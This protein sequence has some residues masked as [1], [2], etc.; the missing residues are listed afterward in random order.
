MMMMKASDGPKE[1]NSVVARLG[2]GVRREQ[3]KQ[4]ALMMGLFVS[5]FLITPICRSTGEFIREHYNAPLVGDGIA[6]WGPTCYR[7]LMFFYN[8]QHLGRRMDSHIDSMTQETTNHITELETRL[9]AVE[10]AMQLKAGTR[11]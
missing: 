1:T 6:R 2:D 5:N 3:R 11:R 4:R 9:R 8:A 7:A 10:D